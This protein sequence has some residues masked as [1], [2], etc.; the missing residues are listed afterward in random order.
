VIQLHL[1]QQRGAGTLYIVEDLLKPAVGARIVL[2]IAGPIAAPRVCTATGGVRPTWLAQWRNE[3]SAGER[4]QTERVP[5]ALAQAWDW[6][7]GQVVW[8]ADCTITSR[9]REVDPWRGEGA[10]IQDM[11]GAQAPPYWVYAPFPW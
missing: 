3:N 11:L 7:A 9:R 5:W 1:V 2:A 6:L 10:A 8:R 4:L